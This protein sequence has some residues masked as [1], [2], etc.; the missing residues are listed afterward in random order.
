ML[1][2]ITAVVLLVALGTANYSRFFIYAGFELNKN[3]IATKLCENRD[4][5][6]LHC[7]GRCYFMKKIN[8]AQESE[9]SNER[10]TQKN[11]FQEVFFLSSTKI[12]FH[13]QLLNIIL[14]PYN[15]PLAIAF[16]GTVFRP[17][18]LG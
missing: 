14:T 15:G 7:N 3:Y 13:T 8:A 10:Q 6:W 4:K 11:L 2:R 18:Q 12:K 16:T 1:N 9:K 5:P 17:P